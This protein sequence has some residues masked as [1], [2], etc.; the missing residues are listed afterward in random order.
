MRVALTPSAMVDSFDRVWRKCTKSS[1]ARNVHKR[2]WVPARIRMLLWKIFEANTTNWHLRRRWSHPDRSNSQQRNQFRSMRKTPGR[3]TEFLSWTLIML[4]SL[5][6][7]FHPLEPTRTPT[8]G[9]LLGIPPLSS[10]KGPLKIFM[11]VKIFAWII[12][13]FI[14]SPSGTTMSK[15]ARHPGKVCH[16]RAP[17]IW[18]RRCLRRHRGQNP[19]LN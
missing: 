17:S 9:R 3:A 4:K 7:S 16:L 10:M 1:A 5:P 14:L 11:N 6:R 19:R 15:V 12:Q 18:N 13:A 8:E 2:W